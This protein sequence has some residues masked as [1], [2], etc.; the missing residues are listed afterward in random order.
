[1]LNRPIFHY[2]LISV[3]GLLIY[4][5]TF[6]VPFHFDDRMYIEENP[7]IKDFR[8]LNSPNAEIP[9]LEDS[10]ELT[11]KTRHIGYLSFFLNYKLH[12]LDVTGYHAMNLLIH[13]LNSILV[14]FF[15]I[16]TLKTPFLRKSS[17]KVHSKHI[18][19]VT[20]LLFVVHPVQTQAVTYICQRFA[21]LATFFYLMSITAYIRS[22]ISESSSQRRAMYA[23]C[24]ISTVIAM[25]TKE[26]TFTLPLMIMLY[27]FMFLK[28]SS[29][30]RVFYLLPLLLT[31]L[32]IPLTVIDFD[33]P[34][35]EALG[36]ATQT[37]T[38]VSRHDYFVTQFRV[39]VTYL[40]LLFLPVN[41]N[42]DYDYQIFHSFF[43][44]QVFTSFLFLL[45]LFCSAVYFYYQSRKRNPELRLITFGIFWFF[46]ALSVES[47]I[48]LLHVIYE[49]RV[50][51]PSAGAF[52][53]TATSVF[54]VANKLKD[55]RPELEKAVMPLFALIIIVLSCT[56][57][58]RNT[59]WQSKTNLW[60]DVVRK[61][62]GKVRGHFNLGKHY[63][64]KGLIERAA[65]SYKTVLRLKPDHAE[66]YNNLGN[67]YSSK[68][69][70]SEAIEHYQ[71]ALNLKPDYI[72]VYNNIGN[73]YRIKG[74]TDKAI[75]YY[76]IALRLRPDY[77]EAYYNLGV[78]YYD[79]GFFDKAKEH[80]QIALQ[81]R[82]DYAEAYFNLGDIY[83]SKGQTDEAIEH[84]QLA[85]R[86]RPDYAEAHIN[87]GFVYGTKGLIDKAIE[88]FQ[89]AVRLKSNFAEAH[90]NLGLAY[91][92]KGL[93]DKARREFQAAI[94]INPDYNEAQQYLDRINKNQ[95]H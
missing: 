37:H 74:L 38:E 16:L 77:A 60:E 21:S 52:V 89:I 58:A 46:L 12:G 13:I 49:H 6:D 28:E 19:L 41:Q 29:K 83:A 50:Y 18:A 48:I 17:L 39:I 94:Q 88:H 62:P 71:T 11:R 2:I 93:M 30:K 35:G 5:N 56:A 79:I 84:Y 1:M 73:S 27:E 26:N 14:Y 33:R 65:E 68:G 64:D 45:L 76:Q 61:S 75:K 32:I 63:Q 69:M 20:G 86:L 23:L 59:V 22:R 42:L 80:Y 4:S 78:A 85:L 7:L 87:L 57:Y 92:N 82:P 3:L 25:K 47:S 95:S 40:R 54:Y 15:V 51:L 10:V 34:F 81:L 66:A 72:D 44:P 67:I 9:G 91:F 36:G 31:M 24:L 70:T 55:R 90:Y 8:Y 43:N 53:V